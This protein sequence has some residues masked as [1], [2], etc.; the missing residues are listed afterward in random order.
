MAV[1]A[2]NRPADRSAEE[3]VSTVEPLES[4]Q[5][6]SAGPGSGF[7][8][9]GHD[10][11]PV[12]SV[13]VHV[14]RAPLRQPSHNGIA[15]NRPLGHS[16][17][18]QRTID[19]RRLTTGPE[20]SK[21][22]PR[23][24]EAPAMQAKAPPVAVVALGPFLVRIPVSTVAVRV[25]SAA[26]AAPPAPPPTASGPAPAA[27]APDVARVDARRAPVRA[28][29]GPADEAVV[30]PFAPSDSATLPPD[31]SGGDVLS[32][33]PAYATAIAGAVEGAVASTAAARAVLVGT[34]EGFFSVTFAAFTD[35]T[36]PEATDASAMPAGVGWQASTE[37]AVMPSGRTIRAADAAGDVVA[38]AVEVAVGRLLPRRFIHIARI[39]ALAA[40]NDALAAF[41]DESASVPLAAAQRRARAWVVTAVVLSV[42][43]ALLVYWHRTRAKQPQCR[44][45]GRTQRPDVPF[46]R[47]ATL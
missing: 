22:E 2:K 18:G 26:P 20:P 8:V 9:R 7:L 40:F 21:T 27:V 38:G 10:T 30:V 47:S 29:G 34:A 5:F 44:T 39:D 11:A 17:R 42:D 19:H 12:D 41:A 3:P 45:R 31:Q 14:S 13:R 28:T 36:N 23:P 24:A 37:G 32:S 15:E 46:P 16:L 1:A 25:E 35:T 43:V 4:R 33:A 6:L